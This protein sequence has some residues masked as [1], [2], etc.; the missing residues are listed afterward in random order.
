M[1]GWSVR[2]SLFTKH[3]TYANQPSGRLVHWDNTLGADDGFENTGHPD[4]DERVGEAAAYNGREYWHAASTR[5][6]VCCHLRE[7]FDVDHAL[8]GQVKV[9]DGGRLDKHVLRWMQRR[10]YQGWREKEGNDA[11]ALTASSEDEV[12]LCH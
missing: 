5:M 9:G 8:K 11:V 6:T 7:L 10:F 1:V 12:A 3:A 2:P 4:A